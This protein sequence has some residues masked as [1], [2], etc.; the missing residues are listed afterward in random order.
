MD[1]FK[2]EQRVVNVQANQ[3]INTMESSLNK[4]LDGFQ[5]EIDQKFDILQESISKLTNQFVHQKVENPEK[6]CL[7]DTTVEEQYK[8]QD[9]AI[10]PLL[11]E[12]GSGKE[13]VEGTQKPILQPIPI[14]LDPNATAQPRNSPLPVYIL[15]S[16]AAQSTPKTPAPKAHVNPSLL[17][18]NI[19]KLVATIRAFATTSKHWQ[20]LIL[21]G[22]ADGSGA[23][24]NMEHL[25]LG[26]SK[27]HQL[28]QPPKA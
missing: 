27:L 10:S 9:K 14:N 6:E 5:S 7:I 1:N 16:P 25:N 15:P 21:N 18:Q 2:E 3:E 22:I 23:A 20:P 19:R 11:T 17:V 12:K 13:I 4:E 24:S 28:Q 8:Q 26:I